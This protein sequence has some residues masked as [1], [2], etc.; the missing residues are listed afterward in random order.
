MADDP[1]AQYTKM[2][3]TMMVMMMMMSM[4]VIM[5]VMVMMVMSR[6]GGAVYQAEQVL[7]RA[8]PCHLLCL[9]CNNC[10]L[11]YHHNDDCDNDNFL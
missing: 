1:E 8:G 3:M 2:F 7:T 10:R 5:M 11:L 9:A 4:V 6:C